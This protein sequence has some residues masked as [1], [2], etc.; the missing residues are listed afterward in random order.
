[1]IGRFSRHAFLYFAVLN[2]FCFWRFSLIEGH[3]LSTKGDDGLI[4]FAIIN[5]IQKV[6]TLDFENW[7]NRRIYYPNKNTL[8]YT[9]HYYLHS[10]IGF[11]YYILTRDPLIPTTLFTLCNS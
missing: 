3:R 10:L 11:P 1:M 8:A 5:N 2:L 4:Q 9:D 7:T 6:L